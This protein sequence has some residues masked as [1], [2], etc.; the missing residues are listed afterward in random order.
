MEK[1]YLILVGNID[2]YHLRDLSRKTEHYI[3]RKIRPLV[4]SRDEFA[5]FKPKMHNRPHFL[6]WEQKSA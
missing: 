6:L 5:E 4:L 1:A 2:Q 3:K